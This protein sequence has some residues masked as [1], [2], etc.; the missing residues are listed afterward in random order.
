MTRYSTPDRW[1]SFRHDLLVRRLRRE[2]SRD[3]YRRWWP[4]PLVF[5]AI[6]RGVVAFWAGLVAVLWHLFGGS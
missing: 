6:V 3:E 5:A 1:Q 2:M 4:R